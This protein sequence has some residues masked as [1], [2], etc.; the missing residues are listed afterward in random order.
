MRL[1]DN[2]ETTGDSER[3]LTDPRRRPRASCRHKHTFRMPVDQTE[4]FVCPVPSFSG[5]RFWRK[6]SVTVHI[7]LTTFIIKL[8]VWMI[9]QMHTMGRRFSPNGP[10]SSHSIHGLRMNAFNLLFFNKMGLGTKGGGVSR[11]GKY[12]QGSPEVCELVRCLGY[13][14]VPRRAT[15][16]DESSSSNKEL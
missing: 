3:H 11:L 9:I 6:D 10:V 8:S 16:D 5:F 4:R 13:P 14:S 2:G 7:N 1:V 15:E 12:D